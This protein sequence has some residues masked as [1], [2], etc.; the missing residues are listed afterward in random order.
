MSDKHISNELRRLVADRAGHCCEYCRAQEQYSPDSFTIDHI[1]PQSL[2]GPTEANNLAFSCYGCNQ[3]KS[4]RTAFADP[5]TDEMV[6][7]FNPRIHAWKDHFAWDE[8]FT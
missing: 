2:D 6:R 7:L 4:T 1:V 5:A 3:H 8:S